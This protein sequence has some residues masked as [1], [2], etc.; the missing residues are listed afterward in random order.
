[1]PQDRKAVRDAL[2]AALDKYIEASLPVAVPAAN[3]AEYLTPAQ[4]AQL[5]GVKVNTLE[6]WRTQGRGPPFVKLSR[7]AVRYERARVL[8]YM[9]EHT[10]ASTSAPIPTKPRRVK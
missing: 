7:N 5:L 8:R 3:D 6:I 4:A 1:M 2:L 10:R 9:Q